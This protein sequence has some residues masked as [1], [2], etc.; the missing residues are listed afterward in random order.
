MKFKK[1]L[2]EG[3][4]GL[5]ITFVDID[6]TLFN[7]FAM[8]RVLKNGEVIRTLTTNEYYKDTLKDD[9]S[10]DVSDYTNAK[11]FYDTSTPIPAMIKR[12]TTI[13]QHAERKGSKVVLLTA[14][15]EPDD[16]K[17]FRKKFADEGIPM[18]NVDLEN[19]GSTGPVKFIPAAKKKIVLK[20]LSSGLYRRA[21]LFDD[22]LATCQV[23]VKIKDD[24]PD[25]TFF[26]VR[27]QYGLEGVP[28]D[29]LITFEAYNV[30]EDGS[31]RKI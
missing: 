24:V 5:G 17:L 30:Q 1:Y 26:K 10:Y 21:R 31:V 8:V 27:E 23:F 29:E 12:I 14:R 7:T 4:E 6:E 9:E 16:I 28:D 18:N 19:V 2:I 3:K 13:I 20:Y 15:K 25:T 22:L 11:L